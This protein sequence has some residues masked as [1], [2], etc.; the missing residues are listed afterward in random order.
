MGLLP[1]RHG[2]PDRSRLNDKWVCEIVRFERIPEHFGEGCDGF[3]GKAAASVSSDEGVVEEGGGGGG[4][5]V[6]VVEDEEAGV[7]EGLGIF[8]GEGEEFDEL[9]E[10]KRLAEEAGYKKAGENGIEGLV[11]LAG[12]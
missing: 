12:I 3:F 1:F 5:I 7:E 4:G 11:A 9:A 8:A 6:E 10:S 2:I